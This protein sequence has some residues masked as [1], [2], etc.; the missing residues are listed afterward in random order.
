LLHP[1][2]TFCIPH[3]G[4]GPGLGPIGVRDHLSS[5]L[6]SHPII[7][8]CGGKNSF[9]TVAAAPWSSAS[10]LPIPYMYIRMMGSDG[11]QKATEQSILNANYMMTRLKNDYEVLYK[12]SKGRCA[13]EF[14][15]DLRMFKKF[16]VTEEDVAKRLMDFNFHA[17]TMSWPVPGT[18]MI[19]PT[20][21]EPKAELDRFCEAMISIRR[22]AEKVL[23]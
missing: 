3:G 21:S 20:E 9:G 2:K 6:P 7:E 16:G 8:D 5:F 13:H 12:G 14:I 18:L 23:L 4:G 17:P 10:I 1:Y 11:L 15:I 19:E 22:E